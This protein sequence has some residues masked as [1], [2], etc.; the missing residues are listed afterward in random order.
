M[1]LC[2]HLPCVLYASTESA[3][4][5]FMSAT[6]HVTYVYKSVI[7]TFPEAYCLITRGIR[8]R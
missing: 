3:A 4:R 5:C 8:V 7:I 1:F 6:I 2:L